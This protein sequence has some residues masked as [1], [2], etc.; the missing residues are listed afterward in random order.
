MRN[1]CKIISA[2]WLKKNNH[3]WILVIG[4]LTF[5]YISFGEGVR[6]PV[7]GGD[8]EAYYLNF[9]HHI[10]VAPLYPLFIHIVE[11]LF[12]SVI[13]LDVV[14]W[15]QILFLTFAVLY[16]VHT[17]QKGLHLK[18]FE[19]LGVWLA[20]MLP[21]VILLP[22]DPIGHTLMT[23]SFT[24]PL[25]YLVLA[26]VLKGI[27]QKKDRYF[28]IS[29]LISVVAGLVRSQM[30]FLFAVVGLSYFYTTIKV[31]QEEGK[32]WLFQKDF[33]GRIVVACALTLLAMK[34]ISWMTVVYEKV[35]FD[36]PA[37][38]YSDQTLVQHMLYL[39]EEEDANLFEDKDI[40][41][42]FLRCYDGMMEL[43][44]NYIHQEEGL[45]AWRKIVGDCGANSYLLTDVIEDYYGA[46]MPTD[47][48]ERE[49]LIADISHQLAYPLLKVHWKDK[50]GE[51]FDLIPA[52]F[53][54]T[55]L[56]HKIEIYGLIHVFT[57][58]FYVFG[59]G[60][61]L[62][63]WKLFPLNKKAGEVLLL[64]LMTSA[65]NVISCN[66]I[67]FGLQRYLAY[68]MGLNWVGMLLIVR[69]YGIF[70][71]NKVKK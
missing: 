45:E 35:F 62:M 66:L 30:L 24:Y 59:I 23:E 32:K 40:R 29:L 27:W 46:D 63:A 57:L 47:L 11:S 9:H 39:A 65:I 37:V 71:W 61:S 41:E 17:I 16:L 6:G 21:F 14:A 44:S 7:M 26:F 12:G 28:V 25:T 20:S 10:G 58:L 19:V 42:I 69:E 18:W 48:I 51:A 49:V 5:L 34:S 52:G 53:I 38:D 22:E 60:A 70:I 54:S 50:L 55:V 13:Y 43:E 1:R 68:T 67:H 33:W 4:L 64:F 56:F 31:R 15:I 3:L 2:E 36:A 8:T